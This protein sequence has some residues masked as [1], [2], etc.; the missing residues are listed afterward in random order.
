MVNTTQSDLRCNGRTPDG[1]HLPTWRMGDRY[2]RKT[3][4]KSL[5]QDPD[6]PGNLSVAGEKKKSQ[7]CNC[8]S[9]ALLLVYHYTNI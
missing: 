5:L 3:G 7:L 2:R 8:A 1:R 4:Q 9:T 6:L